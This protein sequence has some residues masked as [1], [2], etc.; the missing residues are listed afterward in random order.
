MKNLFLD[1]LIQSS[2]NHRELAEGRLK[3][4]YIREA[5]TFIEQNYPHPITVEDIATFCNLN[6][7]YLG[8]IFRDSMNQTLQQFL[9]YYRMNRATEL[10]KFTEM[11][12]NEVGRLVGYPNQLHFSRAF[13]NVFGI[14]PNNWRKE[15]KLVQISNK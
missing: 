3:D 14:S 8:K 11:S 12:V 2:A 4:F 15:N 6:R 10:L 1:L 7:S 13:K 5:I 9:I